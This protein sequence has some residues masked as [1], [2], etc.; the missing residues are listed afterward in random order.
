M[1]FQAMEHDLAERWI[2]TSC[3]SCLIGGRRVSPIGCARTPAERVR[4]VGVLSEAVAG[5][6]VVLSETFT[7]TLSARPQS[8]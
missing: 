3:C 2:V 7:A 4:E 8:H 1:T 5:A 6:E